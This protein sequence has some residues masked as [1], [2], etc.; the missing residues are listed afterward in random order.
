[1]SKFDEPEPGAVS[2]AVA[3]PH[4]MFVGWN[5]VKQLAAFLGLYAAT[6][7]LLDAT[8]SPA[9]LVAATALPVAFGGFALHGPSPVGFCGSCFQLVPMGAA[10]LSAAMLAAIAFLCMGFSSMTTGLEKDLKGLEPAASD[11]IATLAATL[12]L[13]F[14]YAAI[15]GPA[16]LVPGVFA[17]AFAALSAIFAL[18]K[19][20]SPSGSS[21][22]VP[23]ED[24]Q[25]LDDFEADHNVWND[26]LQLLVDHAIAPFLVP[27]LD[28]SSECCLALTCHFALDV[29]TVMQHGLP[30]A[31]VD[32]E[33]VLSAA[34]PDLDDD[35]VTTQAAAASG[36]EVVL[37]FPL[38]DEV[39]SLS[40]EFFPQ[41]FEGDTV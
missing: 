7:F 3:E 4:Q 25:D 39:V 23:L 11:A 29:F 31:L 28:D 18:R 1:M 8:A 30:G 13:V 24:D 2:G 21:Q 20:T 32:V 22:V 26:L 5:S 6:F 34:A 15:A 17:F 37:A 33:A 35:K 38:D 12:P 10:M 40:E 14:D 36:A 19:R 9:C 41:F 16:A 27:A